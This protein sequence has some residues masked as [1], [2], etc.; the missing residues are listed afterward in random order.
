MLETMFSFTQV[1]YSKL[2]ED[3]A[4]SQDRTRHY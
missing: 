1:S 3:D 2:N 4:E